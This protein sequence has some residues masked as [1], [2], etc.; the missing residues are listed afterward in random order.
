M[1]RCYEFGKGTEK[2]YRK[3]FEYYMQCQKKGYNKAQYQVGRCYENGIGVE[4]DYQ[5]ALKNY[6]QLFQTNPDK[7]NFVLGNR[8][9]EGKIVKKNNKIAF[10]YY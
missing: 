1:G 8:F 6:K 10:E 9:A 7:S 2:N 3:A 4:I 5:Q